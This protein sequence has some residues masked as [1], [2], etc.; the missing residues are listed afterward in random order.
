VAQDGTP[1]F[2]PTAAHVTKSSCALHHP[3]TP[4]TYPDSALKSIVAN[5]YELI[6]KKRRRGTSNERSKDR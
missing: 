1:L 5:Q 3:L 6:R 4:G 2:T